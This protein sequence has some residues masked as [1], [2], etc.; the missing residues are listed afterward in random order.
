[1]AMNLSIEWAQYLCPI[2][3]L[4]LNKHDRSLICEHNHCFD[5]AKEGYVNL[6]PVQFKHSKQPGDNKHMV[7]ARQ[8]FLTQGF[9]QP[10]VAKIQQ[11][12]QHYLPLVPQHEEQP[13]LLD[14]G[15]AVGY[16]THQLTQDNRQVYGV[17]IAKNAVKLAAK[18]YRDC[19]F[20]VATLSHLPFS[21]E[22]FHAMISVYAPIFEQEFNRV[23]R[24]KGY[25]ICVTP[26]PYH[27]FEL[28]ALLYDNVRLHDVSREPV[29]NFN[30]VAQEQLHYT[31]HFD[32][33]QQLLD[34]LSMTPFSYKA[35]QV[36]RHQLAL[37]NEF[38]C[39]AHFQLRLYQKGAS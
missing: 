29:K 1:M 34:L 11:W 35:N 32:N 24:D 2:C 20:S 16:Y 10:L 12:L 37:M 30:L 6:L 23:L 7:D 3:Q 22:Y 25:L 5:L 39:Q 8:R 26:A 14:L 9:Y 4:P 15:C 33:N 13:K 28:K 21:D 38:E 27:L 36:L 19:Y 18:L 17:D 31:M